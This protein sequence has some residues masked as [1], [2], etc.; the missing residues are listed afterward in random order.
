MEVY[1]W[2]IEKMDDNTRD[3]SFRGFHVYSIMWKMTVWKVLDWETEPG[4][5]KDCGGEK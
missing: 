2:Y 1:T 5:A 4:S 3:L